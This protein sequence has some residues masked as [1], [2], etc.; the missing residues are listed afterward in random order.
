MLC[1]VV[2]NLSYCVSYSDIMCF[3]MLL[4]CVSVFIVLCCCVV[5]CC[6]ALLYGMV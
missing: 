4:C 2:L 5:M 1:Y 3:E 6:V